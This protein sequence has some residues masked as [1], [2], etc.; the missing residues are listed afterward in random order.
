MDMSQ[1]IA[2]KSDQ[3]NADDLISG[4]RDIVIAGVRGMSDRDQPVAVFFEGD[5]GKPYK[6]CKSMRRV[7]VACWG[8]DA[9]QYIGRALRLYCDPKVKFGGI[10]V[11]GIRISHMSHIDGTQVFPLTVSKARRAPYRIE[12]MQ[13]PQQSQQ[14][15]QGGEDLPSHEDLLSDAQQAAANGTEAL[16]GHWNNLGAARQ[17]ILHADLED[18]KRAAAVADEMQS[19]GFD[20][21]EDEL[22][23]DPPSQI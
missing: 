12:P 5:N 10:E 16:R 22:A 13:A 2:P 20:S 8:P 4:P 14:Q 3:L 23:G 19:G 18:L 15:Q 1:T 11:G 21:A 7:M 6:P 17:K 9:Q